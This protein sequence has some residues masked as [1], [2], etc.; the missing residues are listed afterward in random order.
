M[1]QVL[2]LIPLLAFALSILVHTNSGAIVFD[3]SQ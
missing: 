2:T 1:K 3:G